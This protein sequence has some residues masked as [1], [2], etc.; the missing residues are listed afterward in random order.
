MA[1]NTNKLPESVTLK[2]EYTITL[3]EL[4]EYIG[5]PLDEITVEV[6]IEKLREYA[7][8]ACDY[9]AIE[10]AKVY[11]DSGAIVSGDE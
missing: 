7:Y 3:E 11:D 1:D 2:L 8:E 9:N 6:M 4:N 10:L 5:I